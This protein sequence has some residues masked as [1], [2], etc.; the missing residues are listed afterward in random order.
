MIDL[1]K[2]AFSHLVLSAHRLKKNSSKKKSLP[3]IKNS[4]ENFKEKNIIKYPIKQQ[5]EEENI[6]SR[7]IDELPRLPKEPPKNKSRKILIVKKQKEKIDEKVSKI[8]E[9][10]ELK[11]LKE[12]IEYVE[13]LFKKLKL[14]EKNKELLW[15][16]ENKII[17]LKKQVQEK[18]Y[19]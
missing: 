7:V 17:E 19:V 9:N 5:A 6:V 4:E 14:K 18:S 13:N 16:I 3:I 1:N 8:I 15:K 2:D 10:P 11:S 12:E